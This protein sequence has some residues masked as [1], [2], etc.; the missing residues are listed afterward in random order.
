MHD[1]F[2]FKYTNDAKERMRFK[3]Q[4]E[5]VRAAVTTSLAST[6]VLA[7]RQVVLLGNRNPPIMVHRR[8]RSGR[9]RAVR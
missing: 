7:G 1:Y 3:V 9:G 2:E 4:K 5:S 8:G 6:I